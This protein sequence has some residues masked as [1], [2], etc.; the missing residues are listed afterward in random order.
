MNLNSRVTTLLMAALAGLLSSC[1]HLHST[2]T[3]TRSGS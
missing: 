2:T 1:A 3:T